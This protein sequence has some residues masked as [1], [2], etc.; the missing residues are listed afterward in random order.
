MR[1]VNWR[2]SARISVQR[3]FRCGGDT[4]IR[5]DL[6]NNSHRSEKHGAQQ[7]RLRLQRRCESCQEV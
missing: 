7:G 6:I 4:G 3:L 5:Y 2:S 1:V